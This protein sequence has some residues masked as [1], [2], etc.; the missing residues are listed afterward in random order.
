MKKIT[1]LF[2]ILAAMLLI[3]YLAWAGTSSK[4]Y[5]NQ[6]AAKMTVDN[7]GTIDVKSGGYITGFALK[8]Q[9]K[10]LALVNWT[11]SA[12]EAI[13]NFLEV[14]G[15]GSGTAI[16]APDVTGRMYIVR[17]AVG[18]GGTITIK[19]SSGTGVTIAAGYTAVVIHDGTDYR[20]VSSV[21]H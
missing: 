17:N 20:K 4:V 12:T 3:A 19:K 5:F 16:I 7:G 9:T 8:V 13:C 1:I 14:T 15:S 21:A 11:L 10:V 18:D 6:G 2:C